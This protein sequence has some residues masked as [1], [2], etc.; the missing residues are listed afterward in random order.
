[1]FSIHSLLKEGNSLKHIFAEY[2]IHALELEKIR[3]RM[4]K[5]ENKHDEF[6]V[7]LRSNE[8]LN[9]KILDALPINIFLEDR[10]GRTI[11]ANKQACH[12]HGMQPDELVGKTVY[13]FF[14]LYIANQMRTDDLEVWQQ[15]ELVTKETTVGFQGQ[16]T[17]MYTGK[18]I[19]H[20]DESNE[21]FL[22][23]FGL[24]ITDRVKAEKQL[25]D[26]EEKFRNLVDQAADCF[27]LIEK[28]GLIVDINPYACDLLSSKKE[29][30]LHLHV[31]YLFSN[32]SKKII[33]INKSTDY[34]TSYNFEDYLKKPNETSIPVDI[35]LR[36]INI[37]D[38]QMY[39]ALCR[40]I[41]E[42]KKTEAKIQHM[43][44]HD[45][46]TG[47][48]NRWY[49]LSYMNQFLRK[50][51]NNQESI[52]VLLL[53]LDHFKV[54]NDSLGH[55]AGDILLQQVASRLKTIQKKNYSLARLGGDEF[56]FIIP[57]SYEDEAKQI[58][59]E[60]MRIMTPPFHIQKQKINVSTS[61]GIS[62]YPN[63]G[64]D[65]NTLIKNADIAMYRSKEQ[66]RN[67]Y[68]Q[69]DSSMKEHARKRMEMEI[70]LREALERKE[71][72]LHYQPKI[73]MTTGKISGAEALVR[74]QKGENNLIYPNAF[75][76]VAEETGLIVQ[77]GERVIREACIRCK[78]WHDQGLTD[79][80]ISVN[81]SASQFHKQDIEELIANILTETGL[82]PYALEL[83]LTES[84]VM[85]SPEEAR[86]VLKN[87]K[88]LGLKISIDDFGTGFSSLSYL[89]HFPIDTLKIDK[90]F[91]MNLDSDRANAM[92]A[93]AVISLAHSL[94]LKVVA[95]GVEN[96][97]Q[98]QFL[99]SEQCDYAQG[100]YVSR[101]LSW[102]KI[103]EWI[104]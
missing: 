77:I 49:L 80:T 61:I 50:N 103:N 15:K 28:N 102:D 32:L 78:E 67:C 81:I 20:S 43:A 75:I 52:S 1:M 59:S 9:L 25:R 8:S 56:I 65:M 91:I 30:L 87:L 60:V 22:L 76:Q 26:S 31:A 82:P 37:S 97:E 39:L 12:C 94:N 33:N 5:S 46:L 68:L 83:E 95:E 92:I 55:Q 54:I 23:G 63:D 18:T 72:V 3:L 84:T 35:N 27:F 2:E 104:R 41:S 71:F 16:E 7:T 66:G 51:D 45:A 6:L 53:D 73:N 86:V 36:L 57:N 79:L 89:R 17:F 48:P 38:R 70:M 11:F 88:S 4:K 44:F 93:K 62:V 90:S 34:H 19:I 47:L 85:K 64:E 69:F 29:D 58:S 24:D 10:E 40:D 101:P 14:P 42:K 100:Y 13:D 21:E 99:G 74:W 96:N 98:M